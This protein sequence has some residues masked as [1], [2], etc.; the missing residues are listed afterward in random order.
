[1]KRFD[2][3]KLDSQTNES[4]GNWEDAST[5]ILPGDLF[6]FDR[7]FKVKQMTFWGTNW[8]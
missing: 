3:N 7:D 6:D 8:Y 5:Q 2:A 4:Q 1:M